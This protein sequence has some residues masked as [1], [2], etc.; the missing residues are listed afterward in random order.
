MFILSISNSSGVNFLNVHSVDQQPRFIIS[1]ID[2][3]IYFAFLVN[4]ALQPCVLKVFVSMPAWESSSLTHLE[5]VSTDA[6]LCGLPNVIK[7]FPEEAFTLEFLI[8]L[9]PVVYKGL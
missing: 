7:E 8:C 1:V 6:F 9:V 3:P 2:N 5:M 4:G